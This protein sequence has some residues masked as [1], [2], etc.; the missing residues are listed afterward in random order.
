MDGQSLNLSSA[1]KRPSESG[2]NQLLNTLGSRKTQNASQNDPLINVAVKQR[3]DRV[4]Y[5]KQFLQTQLV[6]DLDRTMATQ[7]AQHPELK[8]KFYIG[9][10]TDR[11]Y[12]AEVVPMQAA[13]DSVVD[14]DGQDVEALFSDNPVGYYSSKD[15]TLKTPNEAAFKDFKRALD[16]YFR[17][18][19]DVMTYLRNNPEQ[20]LNIESLRPLG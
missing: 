15:F 7:L 14:A 10:L 12:S 4:R 1:Y 17:R 5:T 20:E 18:N 8:G 19:G 6:R 3:S 2:K 13:I 9:I 16:D 11:E